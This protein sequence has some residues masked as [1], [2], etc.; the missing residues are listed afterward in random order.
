ML[1]DLRQLLRQCR[2]VLQNSTALFN[3]CKKQET[4]ACAIL[5]AQYVA[6]STVVTDINSGR[7][8]KI[9]WIPMHF[10]VINAGT[11]CC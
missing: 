11:C 5:D 9:L 7:Q 6:R 10:V 3:S 8:R 1:S 4:K 2:K